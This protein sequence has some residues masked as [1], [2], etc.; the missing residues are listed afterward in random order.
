MHYINHLHIPFIPHSGMAGRGRGSG[1]GALDRHRRLQRD[2]FLL[3]I[4]I[5]LAVLHRYQ[6]NIFEF[7][8]QGAAIK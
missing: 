7:A 1:D 2:H 4:C 6:R 5:I 8:L 3:R